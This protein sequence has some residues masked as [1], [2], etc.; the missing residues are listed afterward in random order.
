MKEIV[1]GR[2]FLNDKKYIL[3]SVIVKILKQEK[4]L[5]FK[6]LVA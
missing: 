4:E 6:I 2:Q 5:L 1:E 3:E